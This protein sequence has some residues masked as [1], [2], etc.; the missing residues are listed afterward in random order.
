MR[1]GWTLGNQPYRIPRP[2]L[3]IKQVDSAGVIEDRLWLHA[4]PQPEGIIVARI[5]RI[6][7]GLRSSPCAQQRQQQRE[8]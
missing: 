8:R 4:G 3:G 6:S 1:E 2:D 5:H 7:A